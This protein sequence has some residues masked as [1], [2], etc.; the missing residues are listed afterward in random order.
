MLGILALKLYLCLRPR[1]TL[2][3]HLRD[4]NHQSTACIIINRLHVKGH[5][6]LNLIKTLGSKLCCQTK[7]MRHRHI[8]YA[9]RYANINIML[10]TAYLVERYNFH[11]NP[12]IF[13]LAYKV[14]SGCKQVHC[15]D[16][17][18]CYKYEQSK[19]Q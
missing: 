15:F 2:H 14:C 19:P 6:S 10:R 7:P 17:G 8:M 11:I 5:I 12:P 16:L 1:V 13:I 18:A 4:Q 9:L 3:Q